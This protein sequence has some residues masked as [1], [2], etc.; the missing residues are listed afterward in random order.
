MAFEA[1]PATE[2]QTTTFRYFRLYTTDFQ[3][4]RPRMLA[5]SDGFDC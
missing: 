4:L 3:H 5:P 2:N 1:D